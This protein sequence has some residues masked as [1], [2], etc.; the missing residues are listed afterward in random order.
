MRQRPSWDLEKRLAADGAPVILGFDEVGRGAL[1][2]PVMVGCAAIRSSRLLPEPPAIPAHLADS[3]MLTERERE[4][5]FGPLAAFVDAWAVGSASNR[6][7]D[8][9]GITH[10]LGLAALR[11]LAACEEKLVGRKALPQEALEPQ[12]AVPDTCAGGADGTREDGRG[13]AVTL[14]GAAGI[15]DGPY[16]YISRAAGAMDAP[17]VPVLPRITT[18]VRADAGCAIVSAASD[19]AKVSRDR[20]MERLA[21]R[22]EYAVYGWES[23]KGYGTAAHRAAIAAHGPSDLHRLTWH[24]V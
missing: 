17:V 5:L 4:G 6:E 2:G 11:A 19:L 22:P 14:A 24:L 21:A 13:P 18:Q 16:D 3:K 8:E 20:L 23:N 12:E 15:L 1:A 9:A 7:I 10:A